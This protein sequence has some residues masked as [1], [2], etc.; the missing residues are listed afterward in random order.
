MTFIPLRIPTLIRTGLF[1]SQILALAPTALAAPQGWLEASNKVAHEYTKAIAAIHPEQGSSFG[2]REYDG[3]A[4]GISDDIAKR[5]ESILT[6]WEKRIQAEMR[7]ASDP[8]LKID[9]AIL[10]D[11]IRKY[12]EGNALDEKFGVVPFVAVSQQVFVNLQVLVNE[13]SQKDRKEKAV[14]RFLAYAQGFGGFKPFA[15][16]HESRIRSLLKQGQGNGLLMPLKQEVELYLADSPNYLSGI[17]DLLSKSGRKGW[18]SEFAS[19][20]QQVQAYDAFIKSEILPKSRTEPGMPLEIYS[21]ILKAYGVDKDPSWLI[22]RGTRDYKALYQEFSDLAGKLARKY[23]LKDKNPATVIKHLKARQV[24]K[25]KDVELLYKK[26]DLKLQSI[27]ETQNLVTLPKNP[28]RI[29][30]ADDTESRDS[31]VPHLKIAPLIDNKGERHEFVVPTS[32]SGSLP[33][34]DFS[35][36]A[37]AI[38]LL[39]HEGR[40]GHELQFSSILD[41]GVS[42]IRGLYAF[43]SVNAEGWGLY[44]EELVFPYLEPE[45]QL[46]ALQTRL[47]RMAR[48]FLDPQIQTGAVSLTKATE[49]LTRE[50]GVSEALTK[51]D[52]DRYAF[53]SP[54]QATAY[55][56]GLI[57]V[58]A[59]RESLAQ[60]VKFE[61]RCLH[62]AILHVGLIPLDKA[63]D[64]IASAG[65]MKQRS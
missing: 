24:T 37:A 17:K 26:A 38:V 35:Y 1:V 22:E 62:D 50:L 34:D 31:P 43:N 45:S 58:H 25:A 15:V 40:P 5:E 29:R 48:M 54:G 52:I 61:P 51:L 7:S 59:L 47:W 41:N 39:A 63:G 28:L 23:K 60:R 42:L 30:I 11:H 8:N 49:V 3:K 55:Y 33:F 21:H 36:E 32:S 56:F 18:E 12:K 4:V 10:S 44:A 53:R 64:L 27:I 19:F 13:Q 14:D 2:L 46:V 65:C 6:E 9:L 20:T 16:A 57:K